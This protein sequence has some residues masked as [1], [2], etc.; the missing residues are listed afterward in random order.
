[1]YTKK[2]ESESSYEDTNVLLNS[3]VKI[4]GFD[5]ILSLAFLK[6]NIF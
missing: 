3:I 5:R 6:C 4:Q 2:V 1:M